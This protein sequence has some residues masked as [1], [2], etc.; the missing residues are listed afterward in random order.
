MIFH[1]FFLLSSYLVGAPLLKLNI[2]LIGFLFLL[3]M[4]PDNSAILSFT[5]QDW[6]S[7]ITEANLIVPLAVAT[8]AAN[9]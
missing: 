1:N 4:V 6:A 5:F 7:G 2:S 9:S 3:I 8:D